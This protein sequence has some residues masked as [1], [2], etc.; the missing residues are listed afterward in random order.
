MNTE[1][2]RRLAEPIRDFRM[3]R[4]ADIPDVGLYLEQTTKYIN[5]FLA[6][7]GCMEVTAS[8]ISNYVK[9]GLVPNPI[10]KQYSADH[11]ALLFFIAIVKNLVAMENIGLL[12]DIQRASYP[13]P[14]AYDYFCSELENVLFFI[15]GLKDTMEKLGSTQSDEKDMLSNLIYSAAIVI[16]MNA[17][18]NAVRTEHET[19][20]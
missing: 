11:I 7:L 12:F 4:Y 17:R 18:F 14:V 16:H 3:P 9:K 15:F 8:M 13:L 2:K 5:G 1:M 6:P 10:K 19:T 20:A